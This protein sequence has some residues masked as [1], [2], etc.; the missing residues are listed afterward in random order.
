[1]SAAP[2]TSAAWAQPMTLTFA[3]AAAFTCSSWSPPPAMTKRVS[4]NAS[5]TSN[6]RIGFLTPVTRAIQPTSGVPSS[7]RPR[8]VSAACL[9]VTSTGTTPGG[10]FTNWDR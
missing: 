10:M 4:G 2:N 6:A 8:L 1:M 9:G 3:G 7:S 5:A